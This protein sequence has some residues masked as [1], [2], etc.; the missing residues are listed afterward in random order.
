MPGHLRECPI[1]HTHFSLRYDKNLKRSVSKD[2]LAKFYAQPCFTS[3]TVTDL[4]SEVVNAYTV[5]FTE[6]S[7]RDAMSR[8]RVPY[9]RFS[10]CPWHILCAG[11]L[12]GIA[13]MCIVAL[14]IA[15]SHSDKI[16]IARSRR[17]A[18]F[19]IFR[20]LFVMALYPLLLSADFYVFA[21]M[22]IN[23][24]LMMKM[25]Q[26]DKKA[27]RL[28][29][30]LLLAGAF[31]L[32]VWG[33]MSVASALDPYAGSNTASW[34]PVVTFVCIILAAINPVSVYQRKALPTP[35]VLLGRIISAPFYAVQ[36]AD[37]WA[38][39][40]LTSLVRPMLD[41]E[42][43]IYFYICAYDAADDDDH[44]LSLGHKVLRG[45]L[46]SGP[47]LWR[48]LQCIRRFVILLLPIGK[49]VPRS[50]SLLKQ[51]APNTDTGTCQSD[52]FILT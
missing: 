1:S 17:V 35:F 10:T 28:W 12:L 51:N 9:Q 25:S 11:I 46:A 50:S 40:Q 37:F 48:L 34:A 38:A 18:L 24:R 7:R 2:L 6:N 42:F 47:Y 33:L 31:T 44:H 30:T 19:L 22:G 49:H 5:Y 41:V 43:A 14:G 15:L 3:S 27:F 16:D 32:A 26:R 13:A 20:G 8:L 29:E 52:H 36:F 23:F 4:E 45:F 21:K 39:D